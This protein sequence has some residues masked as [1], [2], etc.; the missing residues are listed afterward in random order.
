MKPLREEI[1]TILLQE[2]QQWTKAGLM[3][4][5]KLDSFLKESMRIHPM[6][7]SLDQ[8]ITHRLILATSARQTM[9]DYKFANGILISKGNVIVAPITSIHTDDSIYENAKEFD[10]FRFSRM[11]EDQGNNHD[12][13]TTNTKFLTFGH[14]L[15]AW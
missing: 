2:G 6:G 10:G 7:Y 13:S 1:E 11:R 5:Y 3:K 14:G 8:V 15:H 4:M 12:S 9:T